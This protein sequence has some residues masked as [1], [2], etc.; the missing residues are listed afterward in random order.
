MRKGKQIT[1][2]I[3]VG[4]WVLLLAVVN[5]PLLAQENQ[6]YSSYWFIDELMEWDMEKD[7]HSKFNISYTPLKDR[8]VDAT[9]QVRKELSAEPGIT[10]LVASHATSGHPSQGF[11]TMKKYA[12]PYWQYLDYM[13][14]W[15]GSAGEGI[16]I[17]PAKPWIDAAHKNGVRI[18]GT[19]F[20][21]PNVYG[22]KEE[23]VR[24]FLEKDEKNGSFPVADKLIEVAE[25]YRFDGWFINQETHGLGKQEADLMQE[26]LAYY[27]EKGGALKVMW[28]DA[29]IEDG[30]VIW[31]D[32]FNDHNA[33][34]FQQGDK[35]MSDIMFI[36]FGWSISDLEDSRKK[37]ESMGRSSWELYSGIDVQSKS[38]QSYANWDALYN[39]NDEPYT[40]SIGLYWAN[41]TFD[42]SKTKEPEDVYKNEQIF[43]N[44][45]FR[46]KTSW[47]RE[48]EW[49]G[50]TKYF[51]ARSVIDEVP[52]LT[53]F[54]YGL[55]RFFNIG[56]E[57]ASSSEWHNQS[58]QDILPTWQWQTDTSMVKPTFD[59]TDS[60]NGG[61]CVAFDVKGKMAIPL[62]K[63]KAEID[64][65][66][67]M[68]AITK[69]DEGV[70]AS[71][72]ATFSDGTQEE[73]TI[74][75]SDN[76][77]QHEVDLS[78]R[79]GA[80]LNMLLIQTA[81]EGQLKLGQLGVVSHAEMLPKIKITASRY[82]GTNEVLVNFADYSSE[83]YFDIYEVN[84][85][86][87]E[88]WLGRANGAYFYL[89]EVSD[90]TRKLKIITLS[91]NQQTTKTTIIPIK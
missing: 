21:P 62:Y 33:L 8:F 63:M 22:G 37:V 13:V 41:S 23:W 80:V 47:G 78:D 2:H 28:Y 5:I 20:F 50:F 48:M 29:M 76:W 45:G 38:Y 14:Q 56:G 52:F 3:R 83:L 60:Y 75:A 12:L 10:A 51:V 74:T 9:T 68:I 65:K 17:S 58:L 24:A 7:P 79:P 57:Q 72:I 40:T 27:K 1:K 87:S 11:K 49:K 25:Y 55:G 71:I 19:V 66:M 35:K 30:R 26:F 36:D 54:N 16:I 61:S 43:W 77:K 85:D 39:K 15:G 88:S 32:E 70:K 34:Y 6:P 69:S 84:S 53:D 91:E 67:K 73:L 4:V 81:G 86:R 64:G 59:F 31:Q 42:I 82:A 46:F 90:T 44:G 89:Q 18:L